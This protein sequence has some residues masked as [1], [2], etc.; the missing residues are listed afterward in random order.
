MDVLAG[1][2]IGIGCALGVVT[3]L[4]FLWKKFAPVFAPQLDSAH[5][6]LLNP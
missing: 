6:D 4:R 3:L 5:H 2:F 1:S